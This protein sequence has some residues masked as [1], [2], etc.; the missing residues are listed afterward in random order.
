MWGVFILL[1]KELIMLLV[2]LFFLIRGVEIISSK[3]YGKLAMVLIS[4]SIL[5]ALLNISFSSV[6][7]LIGLVISLMAGVDYLL[8]YLRYF[9]TNKS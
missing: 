3:I 1:I 4:I 9:K 7:F 5:M 8:Y 6:V 2:G